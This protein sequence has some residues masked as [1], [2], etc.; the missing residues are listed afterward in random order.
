MSDGRPGGRIR[1]DWDAAF[2]YYYSLG[3]ERSFAKVSEHLGC[4]PRTVERAA[5]RRRWQERVIELDEK[6]NAKAE[7]KLVRERA[8]RVADTLRVIDAARVRFAGQLRT[9]AFRLTGSDFVGL[10]KLENL[11]DGEATDRIDFA[12]VKEA[13]LE[14]RERAMRYMT[15]EQRAAYIAELEEA[16]RAVDRVHEG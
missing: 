8:D 5:R 10:M 12:E 15:P 3:H 9:S 14:E 7:D 11:L 6:A 4:G 1:Y 13:L 16:T 2:D